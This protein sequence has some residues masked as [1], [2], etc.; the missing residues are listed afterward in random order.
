M[1]FLRFA[2]YLICFAIINC[3][4]MDSLKHFNR[5]EDFRKKNKYNEAVHEFTLSLTYDTA[6]Y[7]SYTNRGATYFHMGEYDS[8][9]NDFT[10]SLFYKMDANTY[11]NRGQAYQKSGNF[12]DAIGD[13]AYAL[14]LKP[15]LIRLY[16]RRAVCFKNINRPEFALSD[17]NQFIKEE[18]NNGDALFFRA[19]IFKQLKQFENALKDYTLLIDSFPDKK[20]AYNNRALIL[21]EFKKDFKAA[22]NDINKAISLLPDAATFYDTRG[23]IYAHMKDTSKAKSNYNKCLELLGN[24][25]PRFKKRIEKKILKL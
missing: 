2:F 20:G 19:R 14:D 12:K 3:S 11:A 21:A 15:D 17:I 22:L 18:E 5:G 10:K 25:D 1:D 9:I 16:F 23:D 7:P 8:A 24:K 4:E 13:Y 6:Y